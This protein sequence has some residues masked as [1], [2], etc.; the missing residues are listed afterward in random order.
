[1]ELTLR[2]WTLEDA[3]HLTLAINNSAVQNNLRDGL[4]YPYTQADAEWFIKSVLDAPTDSQYSW[5]IV[6]D[7]LPVGSIGIFRQ[8]NVHRFTGELG[9]YIAQ[10]YWG[11]SI[12]TYAVTT[13]CRNVFEQ[14]DIIRIFAEPFATNTASC[15]VLEKAGFTL[16]G[17]LRN[18]A[19]KNGTVL[20][21]KLY[22]LLK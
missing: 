1:M 21:M 4:P 5:A 7:G 11:R 19:V 10:P 12:T 6:A 15:R 20:D 22:A 14:T 9:Y 8:Q 3:P 2:G 13:A 16:E 18:N 17:V